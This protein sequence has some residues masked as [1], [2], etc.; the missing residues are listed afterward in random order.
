MFDKELNRRRFLQSVGI[1]AAAGMTM[2][3]PKILAQTENGVLVEDK[4]QYGDFIVEKLSGGKFP[5]ECNPEILKPMRSRGNVFGGTYDPSY[6]RPEGEMFRRGGEL[7]RERLVEKEGKLP[8][9]TR[10]DYAFMSSSWWCARHAGG[11]Y[12]WYM[13]KGEGTRAPW[14]PA[15]LDMSWADVSQV[16]K[17]ASTFFGASVA[18]IAKMDPLWIY[19]ENLPP[20]DGG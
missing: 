19:Q 15:D 11:I 14:D 7:D 1:T 5:Y 20:N 17:H 4:S 9:F 3:A 6:V 16:M 12:K 2:G 8:N 18:G 13:D 10:L